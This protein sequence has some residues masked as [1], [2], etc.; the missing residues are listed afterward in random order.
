MVWWTG[1]LGSLL[2]TGKPHG[3]FLQR[4]NAIV[5]QEPY[6]TISYCVYWSI[7]LILIPPLVGVILVGIILPWK[8]YLQYYHKHQQQCFVPN[9]KILQEEDDEE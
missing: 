6:Q 7:F 4:L 9:K 5:H 8:L 3:P 1:N 2:L